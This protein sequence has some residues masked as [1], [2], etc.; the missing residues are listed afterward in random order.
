MNLKVK[1]GDKN[2]E[3]VKFFANNESHRVILVSWYRHEF[4]F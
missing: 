3:Q 1:F 4:C 2:T